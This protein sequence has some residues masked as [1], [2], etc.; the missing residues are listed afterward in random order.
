MQTVTDARTIRLA[1]LLLVS[2]SL[3]CCSY[4]AGCAKKHQKRDVAFTGDDAKSALIGLNQQN[5]EDPFLF[6]SPGRV[7]SV[8]DLQQAAMVDHGDIWRLGGFHID[9]EAMTY[10]LSHS[11]GS[12]GSGFWEEWFWEGRFEQGKDGSWRATQP[13]GKKTWGD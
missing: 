1:T 2:V 4:I 6:A 13:E 12:P 3:L 5:K 7:E 11:Y 9:P 8:S 10:S